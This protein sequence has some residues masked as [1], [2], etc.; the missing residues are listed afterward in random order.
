MFFLFGVLFFISAYAYWFMAT[1]DFDRSLY[2]RD[3][4]NESLLLSVGKTDNEYRLSAKRDLLRMLIA[5]GASF[6]CLVGGT[7][8][9]LILMTQL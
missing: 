8:V 7:I 6:L 4:A 1:I 3:D 2:K 9:V 5:G